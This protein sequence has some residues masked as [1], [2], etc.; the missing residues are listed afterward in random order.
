MV[1]YAGLVQL[2]AGLAVRRDASG[3]DLAAVSLDWVRDAPVVRLDG[4]GESHGVLAVELLDHDATGCQL[5]GLQGQCFL[6]L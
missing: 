3:G 1:G 2:P 4:A 5:H 6:R